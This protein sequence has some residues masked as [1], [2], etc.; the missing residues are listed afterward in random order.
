[1]KE[2]EIQK[3]SKGKVTNYQYFDK[4]KNII[5]LK[6]LKSKKVVTENFYYRVENQRFDTEKG[7]IEYKEWLVGIRKKLQYQKPEKNIIELFLLYQEKG[8][9]C[10]IP[11]ECFW[12]YINGKTDRTNL[13]EYLEKRYPLIKKR[14]F[15]D[16]KEYGC[17]YVSFIDWDDGDYDKYNESWNLMI[18]NSKEISDIIQNIIKNIP[19][20]EKRKKRLKGD[21]YGIFRSWDEIC[22]E[23]GEE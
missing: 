18:L 9:H 1:M 11:V 4:N 5:D 12:C 20:D 10:E 13:I 7:A 6:K 17:H 19:I 23:W 3:I 22:G 2:V 8:W 16:I 15:P 14:K 21:P